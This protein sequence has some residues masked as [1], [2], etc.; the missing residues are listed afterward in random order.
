M[1]KTRFEQVSV[2]SYSSQN[3][4]F[5]LLCSVISSGNTEELEKFLSRHEKDLNYDILSK[6]IFSTVK[7]K[8]ITS[9]QKEL[10]QI[11]LRYIYKNK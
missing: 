1:S 6:A 8:R 3:K 11:I 10:I 7:D 4:L 5:S 9:S 2:A